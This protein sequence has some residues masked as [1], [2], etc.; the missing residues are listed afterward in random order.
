MRDAEC[1][2]ACSRGSCD[3]KPRGLLDFISGQA[4]CS[5]SFWLESNRALARITFC[6]LSRA[7]LGQINGLGLVFPPMQINSAHSRTNTYLSPC[8]SPTLH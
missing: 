4:Q 7:L 1:Y 5:A 2:Q 8:P 6:R 3:F